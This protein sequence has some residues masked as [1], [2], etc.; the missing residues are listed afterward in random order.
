MITMVH[1]FGLSLFP[2]EICCHQLKK[3][4]DFVLEIKMGRM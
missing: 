4:E 3:S 1:K 2:P